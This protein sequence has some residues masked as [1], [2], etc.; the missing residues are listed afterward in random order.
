MRKSGWP[1]TCAPSDCRLGGGPQ[2]KAVKVP[3]YRYGRETNRRQAS[4]EWVSHWAR[5]TW[6]V[7]ESC[8]G[9]PN[10]L[11]RHVGWPAQS[12]HRKLLTDA[13]SH[14]HFHIFA[15]P[16]LFWE[17]R[18][19]SSCSL[20]QKCQA[21]GESSCHS[22]SGRLFNTTRR[23]ASERKGRYSPRV[24]HGRGAEPQSQYLYEPCSPE[25]HRSGLRWSAWGLSYQSH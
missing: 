6:S 18:K 19:E 24:T 11:Q 1:A 5:Q 20:L 7:W 14:Q 16:L 15:L 17:E 13:C 8:S 3:R 23:E 12:L 2:D 25:G 21:F 4:R 22:A 10:C 9:Q